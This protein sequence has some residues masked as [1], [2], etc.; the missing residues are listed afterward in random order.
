MWLTPAFASRGGK[1]M[2]L[3]PAALGVGALVAYWSVGTRDDLRNGCAVHAAGHTRVS[4]QERRLED[5]R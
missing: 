5:V 4:A 3:G 1:V 2:A